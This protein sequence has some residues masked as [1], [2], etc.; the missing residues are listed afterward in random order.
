MFN[1]LNLMK[2]F[3]ILRHWFFIYS[4]TWRHRSITFLCIFNSSK[5][6]HDAI[7][8][9]ILA[10][11]A[12]YTWVHWQNVFKLRFTKLNFSKTSYM[13]NLQRSLDNSFEIL[14]PMPE[15]RH[16]IGVSEFW[17]LYQQTTNICFRF[18]FTTRC[19]TRR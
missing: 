12:Q 13:T 6:V 8:P 11:K 19:N 15:E 2:F 4:K 3:K 18:S 7:W 17:S 1:L 14:D 16:K 5:L 9:Y 10:L